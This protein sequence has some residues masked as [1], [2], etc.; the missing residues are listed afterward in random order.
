MFI[1]GSDI[2]YYTCASGTVDITPE[3][4]VLLAGFSFRRGNWQNIVSP[5]EANAVLLGDGRTRVLFVA[6]DLL[7]FG[8]ELTAFLEGVAARWGLP[9]DAI[10]L[11]ASHTHYAPVTERAKPLLGRYDVAYNDALYHKLAGL[12]EQVCTM[13]AKPVSILSSRARTS[14]NVNRRRRWFLPTL[15]RGGLGLPPLI[16]MAPAPDKARD[17]FIDVLQFVDADGA[18]QAMAWK[19]ACHPA[20]YP[21]LNSVLPEFPGIAREEV[22]RHGHPNLPVVFWQGFAGDVTP[23]VQGRMSLRDRVHALRGG[24]SLVPLDMAQWTG[25]CNDVAAAL[26]ATVQEPAELLHGALT[27][28]GTGVP[29]HRLLDEAVNPEIHDKQMRIHRV[30]FGEDFSLLF[31]GAE[32]CSPYLEMLGA[33][34]RT[35]CVGYVGE[36]F[37][38][39]PSDTQVREGGY[40]GGGYMRKMSLVGQPKKALD[41]TVKQAVQSLTARST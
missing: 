25:W 35:I 17:D 13:Q 16:A 28:S 5:L 31:F 18:L 38:Y 6:A 26:Q 33:G 41:A 27:V 20:S 4:P 24:P 23:N 32:V 12:V 11:S 36:V 34:P 22:R 9:P 21:S 2:P 37:G 1:A 29:L 3:L 30:G 14:L 40:E 15:T 39:L 10:I 8:A 7:Y 19:F